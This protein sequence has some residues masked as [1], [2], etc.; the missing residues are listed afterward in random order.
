MEDLSVLSLRPDRRSARADH[1][2][3]ERQRARY[4]RAAGKSRL[5]Y[6]HA[7]FGAQPVFAD[8]TGRAGDGPAGA[9]EAQRRRAF[10]TSVCTSARTRRRTRRAALL[11]VWLRGPAQGRRAGHAGLARLDGA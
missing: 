11:A 6:R 8:F 5:D 1:R 2:A 10:A 9:A 7:L 3:M 4:R